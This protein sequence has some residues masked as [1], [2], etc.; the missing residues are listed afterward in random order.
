MLDGDFP[1]ILLAQQSSDDGALFLSEGVPCDVV[2]NGEEHQRMQHSL[3][4]RALLGGQQR[5]SAGR[6]RVLEGRRRVRRALG[7]SSRI[8]DGEEKLPVV[9]DTAVE[10]AAVEVVVEDAVWEMMKQRVELELELDP[11]CVG[12]DVANT[13]TKLRIRLMSAWATLDLT[14]YNS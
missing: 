10:S 5:A 12:V 3:Q 1:A 6:Q 4:L 9:A 11:A 8:H 13:M 2:G 7:A 14:I